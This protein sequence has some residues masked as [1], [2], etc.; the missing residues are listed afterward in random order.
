M[1][2]YE[3]CRPWKDKGEYPVDS[4]GVLYVS[5]YW[6]KALALAEQRR[7]QKIYMVDV[8]IVMSVMATLLHYGREYF[9]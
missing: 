3:P 6:K 1:N 7:K 8:I 9:R 4:E 5:P 2:N